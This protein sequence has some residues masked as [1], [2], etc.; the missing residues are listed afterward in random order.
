M[1]KRNSLIAW[2]A[3]AAFAL[4]GC[5]IQ[6][7]LPQSGTSV[8]TQEQGASLALKFDWGRQVQAIAADVTGATVSI[9]VNGRA[10][11]VRAFA[12]TDVATES[13]DFSGLPGG[14][15]MVRVEAYRGPDKI[16]MGDRAVPLVIG[17]RT[18]A[19]VYVQLD[20]HGRTDQMPITPLGPIPDPAARVVIT[21]V[22]FNTSGPLAGKSVLTLL[23]NT[24][25]PVYDFGDFRLV[26]QMPSATDSQWTSLF[27][28]NNNGMPLGFLDQNAT[29][30]VTLDSQPLPGTLGTAFPVG[31]VQ[32]GAGSLA[33]VRQPMY[34]PQV[35]VDY[36]QWGGAGTMFE[37]EAASRGLWT[38]WQFLPFVDSTNF[39]GFRYFVNTPGARGV[40]NWSFGLI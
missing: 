14:D 39:T 30:S 37:P 3:A 27:D 26:Y 33:L 8:A 15:A 21:D 34:Q 18:F 13:L 5:A 31:A 22:A 6:P 2:V 1:M 9:M 40:A 24:G 38:A 11:I 16:G 10:P 25:H 32:P 28:P 36:V 4:T 17:R 12:P 23:N 7:T 29:V 19:S 20:S 35:L